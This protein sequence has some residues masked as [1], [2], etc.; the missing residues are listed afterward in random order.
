MKLVT[1]EN[2]AEDILEQDSY[3]RKILE[4]LERIKEISTGESLDDLEKRQRMLGNLSQEYISPNRE[5]GLG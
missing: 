1:E 3:S 4:V 5:P 2:K